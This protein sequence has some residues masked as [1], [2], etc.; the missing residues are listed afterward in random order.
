MLEGIKESLRVDITKEIDKIGKKM[1]EG[2]DEMRRQW[3][4]MVEK[5]EEDRK[6]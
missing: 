2:R 6:E 4:G 3:M 5:W 1:D